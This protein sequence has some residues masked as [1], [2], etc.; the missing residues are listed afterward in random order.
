MSVFVLQQQP[1]SPVKHME[2]NQVELPKIHTAHPL[3]KSYHSTADASSS[4]PTSAASKT[5]AASTSQSISS[6]R[7]TSS[8]SDIAFPVPTIPPSHSPPESPIPCMELPPAPALHSRPTL[9]STKEVME[10]K[11]IIQ[12]KIP[13]RSHSPASKAR[14]A[15]FPVVREIGQESEWERLKRESR[16][17]D[18]NSCWCTKWWLV[19]GAGSMILG[20][21]AMS[22]Y[23]I[24]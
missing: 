1:F 21:M 14:D 15:P 13:V 10:Y 4:S 6:Y 9:P 8:S 20:P 23:H 16:E 24:F 19:T 2:E 17:E 18:D 3:G 5:S 12:T 22:G 7:T 11:S